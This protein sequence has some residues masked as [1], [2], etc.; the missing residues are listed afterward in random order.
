MLNNRNVRIIL[1]LFIGVFLWAYVVGQVRPAATKQIRSIPITTT[2]TD[3]LGERGLAV[4]G[5]STES[6]DIEVTGTR[7][8]LNEVDSGDVTATVDMASA[9]RG[10]N[11]MTVIVRVPSGI[12]VTER[13]ASK[14]VVTVEDLS[15][16]TVPVSVVYNGTL[17]EGQE[18]TTVS[19]SSDEVI[20]SGAESLVQIVEGARGTID[21][22]K[23]EDK[24]TAFTCELQPVTKDD[25]GVSG[26]TLSQD[27]VTVQAILSST[28]TVKVKADI[29]DTSEDDIVRHV[30]V[31]EEI[32]ITGRADALSGITEVK[33]KAIDVTTIMDDTEV[34]L[35]LELPKGIAVSEES[36]DLRAVVTVSPMETKDL[37]FA[38]G[39]INVK[40]TATGS[41][42]TIAE[43]TE[44]RLTV[45]DASEIL[46]ALTKSDFELS[47]DVS[48]LTAGTHSVPVVLTYDEDLHSVLMDVEAVEVTIETTNN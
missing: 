3:V 37:T 48:K 36:K 46:S 25:T 27:S 34:P 15:Q 32:S 19:M 29:V 14:V 38:P 23:L 43:D 13:S 2:H 16:K 4:S 17:P 31:P 9:S 22:S 33:T 20:V 41:K 11:D 7:S 40:G 10:E 24:E 28:K 45:K 44:I 26:V 39:D 8:V 18:G 12:T 30:E 47:I 42:Y 5:I 21:A 35:L 1:S 6:L